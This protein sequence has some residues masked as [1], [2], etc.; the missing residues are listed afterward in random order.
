MPPYSRQVSSVFLPTAPL[1]DPEPIDKSGFGSRLP[2]GRHRLTLA[3]VFAIKHIDIK[4][5]VCCHR[6]IILSPSVSTLYLRV[7]TQGHIQP[8]SIVKHSSLSIYLIHTYIYIYIYIYTYTHVCIHI[9]FSLCCIYI[10]IYKYTYIH[11][12][13]RRP[14]FQ[15]YLPLTNAIRAS[16]HHIV[17]TIHIELAY[18]LYTSVTLNQQSFTVAIVCA[19]P[20]CDLLSAGCITH[21]PCH[22]VHPPP[23]R[24]TLSLAKPFLL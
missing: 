16:S 9:F 20:N 12:P 23:H 15:S 22:T 17:I 5:H 6:R 24:V 10:L 18:D 14:F 21:H 1:F 19:S 2:T 13:S 8:T 11:K 4:T 7:I 3:P